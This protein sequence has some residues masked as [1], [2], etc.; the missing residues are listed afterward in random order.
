MVGSAVRSDRNLVRAL[1]EKCER[2]PLAIVLK[3]DERPPQSFKE[4]EITVLQDSA[5]IKK[6][7]VE[8]KT[9]D[10]TSGGAFETTSG[11]PSNT[12]SN[13][14]PRFTYGVFTPILKKTRQGHTSVSS[15]S[16]LLS[17]VTREDAALWVAQTP[18]LIFDRFSTFQTRSNSC[19]GNH[20]GPR[21]LLRGSS[22]LPTA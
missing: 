1:I 10:A 13:N 20:R 17:V 4:K 19:I 14:D 22:A 21:S 8:S 3:L 15:S 7:I 12:T 9:F 2:F 6:V 16:L 5:K 11:D 18:S